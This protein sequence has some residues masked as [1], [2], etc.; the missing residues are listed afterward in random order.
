MGN[1]RAG[2]NFNDQIDIDI[3]IEKVTGGNQLPKKVDPTKLEEIAKQSGFT[4]RQPQTS[5]RRRQKSPFTLQ[6]GIKVRP[7]MKIL[8]QDMGEY[9][10]VYDCATFERA[11][12]ALLEKEGTEVLLSKYKEIIKS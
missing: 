11:M 1:E 12:L 8:F 9:L 10:G 7:E 3:D 5:R 6:L 4:S 2:L